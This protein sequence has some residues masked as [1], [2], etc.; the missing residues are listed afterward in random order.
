LSTV[1]ALEGAD[2]RAGSP[3]PEDVA[4]GRVELARGSLSV[5][6][7]LPGPESYLGSPQPDDE[8]GALEEA[9]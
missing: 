4:A 6:D 1:E 2:E 5:L 3:Q 7:L 9:S 8:A